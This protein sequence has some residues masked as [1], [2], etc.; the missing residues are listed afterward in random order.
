[1]ESS[2]EKEHALLKA[3]LLREIRGLFATFAVLT[4]GSPPES[5]E[6][7]ENVPAEK[8]VLLKQKLKQK[9]DA[10]LI[11]TPSADVRFNP[12]GAVPRPR[13]G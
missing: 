12:P 11:V 8:L 7:L 13:S 3:E 2:I 6:E 1:M 10:A 9:L 4:T 5:S